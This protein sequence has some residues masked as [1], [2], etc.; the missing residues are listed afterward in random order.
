MADK[1]QSPLS[2]ANATAQSQATSLYNLG[3]SAS[4]SRFAFSFIVLAVVVGDDEGR[5]INMFF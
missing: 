5:S 3:Y 1:S 2:D 4:Q